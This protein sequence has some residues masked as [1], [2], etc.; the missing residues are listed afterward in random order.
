MTDLALRV[1]VRV[2]GG[3]MSRR[4]RARRS[5]AA[6]ATA[7]VAAPAIVSLVTAAADMG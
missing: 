4:V 7:T 2:S 3:G 5:N 6:P 1:S